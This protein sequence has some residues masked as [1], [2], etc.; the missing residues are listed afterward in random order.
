VKGAIVSAVNDG[1][2]ADKAGVKRGDVI[3][4][5][6]GQPIQDFNSLRNR[7]ADAAPG[8]SASLGIIRDGDTKTLTVKLDEAEASRQAR[9]SEG[10][11]GGDEKGLLGVAAQPLTPEL[12]VQAGLPRNTRGV[13]VQDVNPD[14]R[15]ADAG[16]Q[17]G[18][19]IL[20]VNREAVQSI[21]A[22]RGAMRKAGE[23]PALLL[24]S[25]EGRELFVT[26]RP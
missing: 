21:D 15:A 1:S 5:F 20:E 17:A 3:T 23:R 22:L 26:V 24:V 2:A 10:G 19:V 7:V 12:A 25:R 16:I 14:G 6:N 4:S 9:D 13:L 8:S 11:A 18:D